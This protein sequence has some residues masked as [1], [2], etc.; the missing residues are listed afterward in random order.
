MKKVKL[1]LAGPDV[2]LPNALEYSLFQKKLCLKY[3]F[4][5]LH[6]FD[7]EVTPFIDN[8]ETG[9]KIYIG[10]TDQVSSANIIVANCN[11]F[12]GA[13]IDDGTAYELGYGNALG[14]P[15]YGY[16]DKLIPF[17]ERVMQNY[18]CSNKGE[19]IIDRDGFIVGTQ[20]TASINLMM[21]FGMRFKGGTLVEGNLEKCLAKIRSDI[22]TG[23]IL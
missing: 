11:K 3:G 16:I 10:N 20:F 6:P 7:N 14:K 12:R 1:Y 23:K 9:R 4:I 15:S 2:F 13:C 19:I 8:E 21:E 17:K 22:D 18:E 5:P